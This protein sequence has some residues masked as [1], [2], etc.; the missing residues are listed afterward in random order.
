MKEE[1]GHTTIE[2]IRI[3]NRYATFRP[4]FGSLEPWKELTE[5]ERNAEAA[6]DYM[7]EV[8]ERLLYLKR[9]AWSPRGGC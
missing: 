4:P 1:I 8:V 5:E 3:L 2:R 9:T 6:D 7:G